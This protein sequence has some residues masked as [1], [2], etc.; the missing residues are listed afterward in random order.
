MEITSFKNSLYP[1]TPLMN[2]IKKENNYNTLTHDPS[3][4]K[5]VCVTPQSEYAPSTI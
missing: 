4:L 1:E 5:F 2:S 3:H